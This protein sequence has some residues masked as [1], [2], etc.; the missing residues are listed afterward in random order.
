MKYG[1]VELHVDLAGIRANSQ[2][3]A[4]MEGIRRDSRRADTVQQALAAAV[5]YGCDFILFPGWTLVDTSP[6]SWLLRASADR[7]IVFECL[8]PRA[9]V[10]GGTKGNRPPVIQKGA[11]LSASPEPFEV[12]PWCS[13]QGYVAANGEIAIGTAP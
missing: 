13:W 10:R 1:L 11:K 8:S 9:A 3:N 6:P 4:V 2:T 5:Q 7:T 12:P